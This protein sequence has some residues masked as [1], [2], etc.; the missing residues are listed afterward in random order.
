MFQKLY[1]LKET[2]PKT[3]IVVLLVLVNFL[4]TVLTAFLAW[5]FGEGQ[6]TDPLDAY[7]KLS[8]EWLLDAG[9]YDSNETPILRVLSVFFFITSLVTLN[10]G[11]VAFL[12]SSLSEFFTKIRSGLGKIL[13]SN[14]ILILGWNDKGGEIINNFL[15]DTKV[16]AIVVLSNQ[17]REKIL[18]IIHSQVNT[19]RLKSSKIQII[20]LHGDITSKKDL[21][22]SCYEETQG[23]I[24]LNQ[25]KNKQNSL[26]DIEILKT[27]FILAVSLIKNSNVIVETTHK[28]TQRLIRNFIE[29]KNP[30]FLG[31]WIYLNEKMLM[32]YMLFQA[33]VLPGLT[34]IYNELLSFEG[35]DFN[36]VSLD[37]YSFDNYL[38][39]HSHAIP[40]FEKQ[41]PHQPKQTLVLS[42]NLSDL[43]KK[44]KNPIT[45]KL[46][47]LKPSKEIEAKSIRVLIIGKNNK[48]EII[49]HSASIFMKENN[50]QIDL[51]IHESFSENT[52]EEIKKNNFAHILFLASDS[53][54][55]SESPDS[56]TLISITKS[57]NFARSK[58]SKVIVELLDNKNLRVL[59]DIG[60]NFSLLSNRYVGRIISQ[61]AIN[62][63]YYHFIYDLIT[64]DGNEDSSENGSHEFHSM[65]ARF[66]FDFERKDSITF[67]RTV[68]FVYSAFHMKQQD[69]INILGILKSD[70]GKMLPQFF[71]KTL[72]EPITIDQKTVLIIIKK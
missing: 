63:A 29:E 64:Y 46:I 12:S 56:D 31:K 47:N 66:L 54:L 17:P 18:S 49:K 23:I 16:K 69:P 72:N 34:P 44:Y 48:L 70:K 67:S 45:P 51:T 10:G 13:I 24:V 62:P 71:C 61:A 40:I 27:C 8:L 28:D 9:F 6:F 59:Q 25:Q 21:I 11:I 37:N 55:N 33:L 52:I 41:Y 20:V 38:S 65:E 53:D 35:Y 5:I 22:R 15:Y 4:M 1:N 68:D 58:E 7:F 57:I 3:F 2:H 19:Q 30:S 39:T 43:N 26:Q 36:P 32:G 14:H 42:D 50:L 60:V